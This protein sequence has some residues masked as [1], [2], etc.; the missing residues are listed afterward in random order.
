M[1]PI[2]FYN[3]F[4]KR[5]LTKFELLQAIQSVIESATSWRLRKIFMGELEDERQ[6]DFYDKE[7]DG[8]LWLADRETGAPRIPMDGTLKIAIDEYGVDENDY[9][10]P[11]IENYTPHELY[12]WAIGELRTEIARVNADELEAAT[13]GGETPQQDLRLPGNLDTSRARKYFARAMEAGMMEITDT[14]FKWTYGGVPGLARLG[15]FVEKVY[16]PNNTEKLPE[17]AINRLFDVT[18]IGSAIYQMHNAKDKPQKW[19]SDID[20]KIFFD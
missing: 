17:T 10:V 6:K 11:T 12:K 9:M 3:L 4:R 18:R 8:K 2:E 16:C 20:S 7:F 13:P 15:Y 14:G 1:N 19:K 5:N